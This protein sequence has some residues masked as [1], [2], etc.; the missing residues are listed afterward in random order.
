MNNSFPT[1]FQDIA[2]NLIFTVVGECRF[3][4]TREE[5]TA[6]ARNL[7]PLKVLVAKVNELLA[8]IHNLSLRSG[9]PLPH[10]CRFKAGDERWTWEEYPREISYETVRAALTVSGLR[11]QRRRKPL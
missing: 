8:R 4:R 5:Y 3:N 11:N 10:V 2:L 7:P 9:V 1:P 6:I